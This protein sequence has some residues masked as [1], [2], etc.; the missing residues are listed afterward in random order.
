MR[1]VACA[2]YWKIHCFFHFSWFTER[3]NSH[4]VTLP[5]G[6]VNYCCVQLAF[7]QGGGEVLL[8]FANARLRLFVNHITQI[9]NSVGLVLDWQLFANVIFMVFT[10]VIV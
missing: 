4:L 2:V 5:F 7:K 6:I 3:N 8:A 10:I 1:A 9:C